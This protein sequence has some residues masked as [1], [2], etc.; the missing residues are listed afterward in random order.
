VAYLAAR[1]SPPVRLLPPD[2][3]RLRADLSQHHHG[4]IP[5]ARLRAAVWQSIF[6]HDIRRYRRTLYQRMGDFATL[7]TGPS[8]TAK[9]WPRAPSPSRAMSLR[10]PA[11]GL[12]RRR[13]GVLLPDQY[14]HSPTL[15]ESELFGHRRG[16]FTGV[17]ADRKGLAE[18][19]PALGSV[20]LD[21]F[22]DLTRRFR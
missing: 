6:T 14:L 1:P 2:P 3:A 22:G 21:E 11:P 13:R 15:V 9:S 20:F 7:I 5:A 17:I 18:T 4:S 8:G 12:R 10:R 19:R 16:S